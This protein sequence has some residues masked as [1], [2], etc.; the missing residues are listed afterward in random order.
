MYDEYLKL[1]CNHSLFCSSVNYLFWEKPILISVES[2]PVFRRQQASAR[3]VNV[4][5]EDSTF[6]IREIMTHM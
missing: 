1:G 6:I 4:H 5:L 2:V 3:R